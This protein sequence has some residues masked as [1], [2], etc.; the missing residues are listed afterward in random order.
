[1]ASITKMTA[2]RMVDGSEHLILTM[3]DGS[4]IDSGVLADI[5][6]YLTGSQTITGVKTFNPG[7][8]LDKGTVVH[9]VK[10]YGAVGNGTTDDTAAIQAAIDACSPYGVVYFPA[11]G[12]FATLSP[13]YV[14]PTITLLGAHGGHIDDVTAPTLK[15]LAGFTGAAVILMVDQTTGGYSRVSN[16][17]RIEKISI[18]GVNLTG[19][20]IDG[21]QAQGYVH[22]VYLTDVQISNMPSHGVGVVANASGTAYSWHCLRVHVYSPNGV[23]ITA[24]MTDAG[25]IDCEVIGGSSHGW[26][27]GK[28]SNSI[29]VGCRSEWNSLD[30]YNFGA[31]T[32][33]GQGSGGP[34]FTGCTSD[35]N[36]QNGANIPSTANGNAPITLNACTFRRDGRSSTS[37]SYAGININSTT[38]HV[39]INGCATYPGTNDDG[40]G[41]ATPQYGLY[42]ANATSVEINGSSFHAISEGIHDGGGNLRMA[43]GVNTAERTG[44]TGSPTTVTR[45][46]QTYGSSGGSLDVPDHMAGIPTPREYNLAAWTFPPEQATAGKAG[47]AGTL[48]LAE[49]FV[50]RP[51]TAVKLGWGISIAGAA[52]VTGQNWIGLYSSAGVLLASVGVDAR[53]ATTGPWLET[54]TGTAIVPDNYWIAYL[55]N[56]TTMPQIYRGADLSGGLM[57]IGLAASKLRF[58]TNG[59]GLTTLPANITPASNTSAQFSYF[60]AIG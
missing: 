27:V 43:R 20:T 44:A 26:F 58:A 13:I 56:A 46:V 21:I 41:N 14:P 22:G 16:E 54:I 32:G 4:V 38:Q 57:N 28:A 37:S 45:G 39:I 11:G 36:G 23:G 3:R 12:S 2:A 15:P 42:V 47:V 8:L 25:W 31:G 1:M 7:T 35:R 59:T 29:F 17:Q 50:P 48:Y 53:I 34:I 10:A 6:V 19:S 5:D 24:S 60:G 49:M 51:L 40:T 30:G 33:T 52:P 18:D 9:N 55:V